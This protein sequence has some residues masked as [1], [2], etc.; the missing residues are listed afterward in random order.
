MILLKNGFAFMKTCHLLVKSKKND[1]DIKISASSAM[2]QLVSH[3]GSD[4]THSAI[5]GCA[6][7]RT[8]SFSKGSMSGVT[9]VF[10]GGARADGFKMARRW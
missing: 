8:S 10:T 7:A 6:D 5:L 3:S 9:P 1:A 4:S 2:Q